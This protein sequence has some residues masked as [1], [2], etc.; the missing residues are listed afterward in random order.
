M[1]SFWERLVQ[2]QVFTLLAIRYPDMG[3]GP[4][5]QRKWRS[6]IANGQFMLWR[7]SAYDALG[8]HEVV[9][10]EAAED[11][12][13]A[14]R[15]VRSGGRLVWRVG[16]DDLGTRMYRGLRELI[17]GWSKNMIPAGLQ[18]LPPA[19]RPLAPAVMLGSGVVLWLLPPAAL[20]AALAGAGG[21]KL[22]AWSASVTALL[23]VFWARM[24]IQFGAP[25]WVGPLYPVGAL[26]GHWIL[27]KSWMGRRRVQWKGRSYAWDVY[28]DVRSDAPVTPAPPG[29]DRR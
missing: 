5:P 14:Q 17:A 11:L 23:M 20:V 13:L 25:A 26:V 3:A 24:G 7:R 28:A 9:R 10:Y 16:Y 2:P 19:L 8:G 4:I 18:T 6:A 15:L 22:L 29:R 21:G 27:L 1:E 12:R